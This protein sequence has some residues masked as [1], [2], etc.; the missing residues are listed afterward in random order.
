VNK[1]VQLVE[2]ARTGAFHF[3]DIYP[4][5]ASANGDAR[6]WPHHRDDGWFGRFV[7]EQ[8]GRYTYAIEA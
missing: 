3:E 1:S 7:P 2:G 5:R 6:R 8:T 4:S